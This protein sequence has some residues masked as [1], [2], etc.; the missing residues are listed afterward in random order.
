MNLKGCVITGEVVEKVRLSLELSTLD[1]CWL[2]GIFAPTYARIISNGKNEPVDHVHAGLI[3]YINKYYPDY[4]FKK[5]ITQNTKGST[6]SLINSMRASAKK[7]GPLKL[8]N[9]VLNLDEYGTIGTLL[10]RSYSSARHYETGS[11]EMT[12]TIGRWCNVVIEC[13]EDG[14]EDRILNVIKEEAKAHRIQPDSL[15]PRGW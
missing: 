8:Q 12:L 6:R 11:T 7:L 15:L 1:Y 5:V 2:L 9:E 4:P 13:F 3:R 14:H 10:F